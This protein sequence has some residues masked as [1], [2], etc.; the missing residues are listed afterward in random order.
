V[1]DCLCCTASPSMAPPNYF[2]P[3][4]AWRPSSCKTAEELLPRVTVRVKHQTMRPIGSR[5]TIADVQ[6][7]FAGKQSIDNKY[8]CQQRQEAVLPNVTFTK[9]FLR[10]TKPQ[11]RKCSFEQQLPR[12]TLT[13][14]NSWWLWIYPLVR[15]SMP[16]IFTPSANRSHSS[17]SPSLASLCEPPHSSSLLQET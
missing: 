5:R 1:A 13:M 2:P 10:D 7:P 12:T 14:A 4:S 3:N 8:K 6:Q 16:K 11:D 9:Y 15:H 17:F